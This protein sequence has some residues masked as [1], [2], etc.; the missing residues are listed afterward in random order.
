MMRARTK[1][2]AIAASNAENEALAAKP[3]TKPAKK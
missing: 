2:E 3:P 1:E